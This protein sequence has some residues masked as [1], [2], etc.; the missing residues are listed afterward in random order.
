[1]LFRKIKDVKYR[2]RFQK[3][4]LFNI[5]LKCVYAYYFN[6]NKNLDKYPNFLTKLKQMGSSKTRVVRRCIL[7]N[8]G[9]GSIRPFNISRS[10]LRELFQYGIIPGY[11][12]SA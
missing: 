12:K 8:R 7:T 6:K 3:S 4:E 10:K 5:S 11:K 9:R 1:M 2:K